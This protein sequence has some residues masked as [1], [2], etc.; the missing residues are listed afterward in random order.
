MLDSYLSNHTKQTVPPTQLVYYKGNKY[1]VGS[2]YVSKTVDIYEI[3][4]ELYIYY[5]S[6]LI[7]KHTI[8][9]NKINYTKEHY[10][11]GLSLSLT[12]KT[13]DEIEEMASKSLEKLKVLGD[14]K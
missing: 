10:Q 7:A 9:Q 12:N 11:E 5:Q 2:D 8:S 14:V 1:S 3:S 6:K 13:A 4:N